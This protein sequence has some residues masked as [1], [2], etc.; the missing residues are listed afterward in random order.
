MPAGAR[1]F[2]FQLAPWI[3]CQIGPKPKPTLRINRSGFES[4]SCATAVETSVA[5][6]AIDDVFATVL[7]GAAVFR[8]LSVA[9]WISIGDGELSVRMATFLISGC[10]AMY[11]AAASPTCLFDAPRPKK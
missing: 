5:P 2:G 8:A 7:R 1:I 11:L 10:L 6:G 9:F 3:P 4:F